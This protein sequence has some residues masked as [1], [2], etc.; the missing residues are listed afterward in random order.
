MQTESIEWPRFTIKW[1]TE[2]GYRVSVPE[3]DMD[4][5]GVEVL[6]AEHYDFEGRA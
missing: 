3:L 2:F 5:K 6:R 4:G 1:T